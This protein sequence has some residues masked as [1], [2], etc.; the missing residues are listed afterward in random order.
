M[1]RHIISGSKRPA[2]ETPLLSV[3]LANTP[4]AAR[5]AL[6]Q[7]RCCR[8]PE[9]AQLAVRLLVKLLQACPSPFCDLGSAAAGEQALLWPERLPALLRRLYTQTGSAQVLRQVVEA[10]QL[11]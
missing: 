9:I 1:F 6:E 7:L 4:S 10:T 8:Q 11:S 2:L 3:C 5:S